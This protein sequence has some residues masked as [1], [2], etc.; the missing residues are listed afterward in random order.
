MIIEAIEPV[1]FNGV[2]KEKG[3]QFACPN[4]YAVK[5]IKAKS[6]IEVE[7]AKEE[8]SE[9]KVLESKTKAELLQ[10]AEEKGIDSVS[11]ANKKD[12]IIDALL[13]E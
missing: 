3:S 8:D 2:I 1:F 12:E 5:L 6:A 10:I 11:E 7:E 9:R 4:D 13:E